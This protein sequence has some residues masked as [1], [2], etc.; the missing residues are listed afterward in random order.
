MTAQARNFGAMESSV[1][2]FP[3]SVSKIWWNHPSSGLID[4]T[5]S[6][7]ARSKPSFSL[8][9]WFD[10]LMY[11]KLDSQS[12]EYESIK[13]KIDVDIK[14]DKIVSAAKVATQKAISNS[15]FGEFKP[16][17][18]EVKKLEKSIECNSSEISMTELVSNKSSFDP[19]MDD[20][21]KMINQ[22]MLNA[23]NG[24]DNA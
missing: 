16:S 3:G 21:T 1:S 5:L 22:I 19:V 11:G 20:Y 13:K 12:R 7:L 4:F 15:E 14:I 23:P 2:Y 17:N 8:D 10:T 18:T 6:P 24:S 9:E